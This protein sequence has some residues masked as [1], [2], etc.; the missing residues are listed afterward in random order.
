MWK[1]YDQTELSISK[2]EYRRCQQEV[3][4]Y[5]P[6]TGSNC[7]MVQWKETSLLLCSVKA[8]WKRY[9]WIGISGLLG[10]GRK[11]ML[12][13]RTGKRQGLRRAE[14]ENHSARSK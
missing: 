1:F 7:Y 4:D 5:L 14:E 10:V 6:D 9:K 12:N 8:L 2:L 13:Y 3:H 11:G